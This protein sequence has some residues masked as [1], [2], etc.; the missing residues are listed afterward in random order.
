MEQ[1]EMCKFLVEN[2]ADID[3]LAAEHMMPEFQRYVS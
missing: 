1:P 3:E 2:G